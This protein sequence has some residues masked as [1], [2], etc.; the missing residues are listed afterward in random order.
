M[1]EQPTSAKKPTTA[2]EYVAT[3]PVSVQESLKQLRETIYETIPTA[4]EKIRY[5]MPAV[6]FEGHYVVH[7]GAWKHHIGLYPMPPF[8]DALEAEVAPYRSTKD[9]MK[10][11]HSSPIPVDLLRRILLELVAKR[12]VP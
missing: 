8:S 1:T 6:M 4:T 11:P 10:F 2:E 3:F 9:T 5:G 7:Y 12:T